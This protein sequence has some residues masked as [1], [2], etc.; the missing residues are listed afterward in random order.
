MSNINS[1]TE[2]YENL[3][4]ME[5][6]SDTPLW[7][8]IMDIVALTLLSCGFVANVGTI[9]ILSGRSKLFTSAVRILLRHQAGIDA[10]C[11]VCAVILIVQPPFWLTG[12]R[13][14]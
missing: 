12:K 9:Y 1:T 3:T 13:F 6:E 10:F 7:Y 4:T 14:I 11:S 5:T 2:I 8:K